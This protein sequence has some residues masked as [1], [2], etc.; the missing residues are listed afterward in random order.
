MEAAFH[1]ESYNSEHVLQNFIWQHTRKMFY[2]S[3]FSNKLLK[4]MTSFVN[5]PRCPNYQNFI[6]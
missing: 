2:F 3:W 6:S 4:Y 1:W 5:K